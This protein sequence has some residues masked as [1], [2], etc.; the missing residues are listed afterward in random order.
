MLSSHFTAKFRHGDNMSHKTPFR[1]AWQ[2]LALAVML[3]ACSNTKIR[4]PSTD[5][6]SCPPPPG[7]TLTLN[8]A[9]L[10]YTCLG[11]LSAPDIAKE[12]IAVGQSYSKTGSD[13]DRIKL[14]MLLSLPDTPFH[15]TE[16]ALKLLQDPP[17][18][19]GTSPSGLH[20]LAKMLS[21]L[22]TEQAHESDISNNLAKELAA[23]KAR[24][25]FLQEKIDA[26]KNLE[27][28]MTHRDQP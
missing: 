21:M 7:I 18:K 5:L 19:P 17:D 24:S 9:V 4:G 16:E 27:I 6:A 3:S 26:V 25:N 23:E 1:P 15:S 8:E 28:N 20:A 14:A 12:Y 11:S 10:Y 22:L 2:A 13:A